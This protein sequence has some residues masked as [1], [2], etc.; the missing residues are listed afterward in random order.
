MDTENIPYDVVIC[1]DTVCEKDG[2]IIEKP[3]SQ[4]EIISSLSNF[5]N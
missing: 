5:S 3:K 2:K 1:A 4:E